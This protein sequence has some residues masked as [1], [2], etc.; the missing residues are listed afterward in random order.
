MAGKKDAPAKKPDNAVGPTMDYG[1]SEGAGWENTSGDDFAI[2]FLAVL[3]SNS[4]QVTGDPPDAKVEGALPGMLFNTVSKE[5]IKGDEGVV[6]VP[7][8]TQH[9]YV[10]WMPREK[11]GGFQGVHPLDSELV[12]RSKAA[13][14]DAFGRIPTEQG[15]ELVE[16]FYMYAMLLDDIE[17]TT[18]KEFA[19][20][21]FNSTKIKKYK[22]VMYRLRMFTINANGKKVTPPLFAHRL[23][24][25]TVGEKNSKGPFKNFEL[26]PAIE[27]DVGKSLIPAKDKDGNPHPLLVEGS[28]LL[29]QIRKGL[30]RAAHESQT[31]EPSGSNEAGDDVF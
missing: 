28:N 6:I 23:S 30:A 5:L 31:S 27:N 14:E 12:T 29:S 16:T 22:Q 3:Q 24:L 10:E 7:C 11:G 26:K 20:I 4:P 1:D 18:P 9:V 17:A 13:A 2:P 21:A 15:T 8:D 19:V 25:T